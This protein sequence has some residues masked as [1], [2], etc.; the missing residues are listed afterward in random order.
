MRAFKSAILVG[1]FSLIFFP[2]IAG[3]TAHSNVLLTAN[4][5]TNKYS[6]ITDAEIK[7]FIKA[8]PIIKQK[9][10]QIQGKIK[11][12]IAK[13]GMDAKRF[14]EIQLSKAFNKK[15]NMTKAETDKYNAIMKDLNV[16]QAEMEKEVSAGLP[17]GLTMTR[18][19]LIAEALQRDP[20]TQGRIQAIM[21]N[22]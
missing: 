10:K 13:H 17:T 12:V 9:T 3:G 14:G 8:L 18:F 15:I 4:N 11:S 7:N 16:L 5:T 2:A 20:Q 19:K 6:N 21:H 22:N 1:L